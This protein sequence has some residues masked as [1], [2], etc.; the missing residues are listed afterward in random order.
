[1]EIEF[2]LDNDQKT[3]KAGRIIG[4]NLPVPCVIYLEGEMGTGKTYLS[5]GI[6]AGVGI[7]ED[8]TSPTF[9]LINEYSSK[10]IKIYHLDLYRLDNL[11]QVLDLGIEDFTSDENSVFLI[12][13][14]EKLDGY[15]L[16]ETLLSIK[17]FYYNSG[18]KF[19]IYSENESC[20]KIFERI[21]EFVNIGN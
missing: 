18:R 12:E 19:V 16:S 14:A 11:N 9:T 20:S 21:K 13:W 7:T 4:E 6:A 8:I 2:F 15:K 3:I 5:K 10:G 17:I 1:M